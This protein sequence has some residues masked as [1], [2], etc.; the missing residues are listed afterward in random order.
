[1]TITLENSSFQELSD[2]EMNAVDGGAL[3]WIAFGAVL[4]ISFLFGYTNNVN[5]NC[6]C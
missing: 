3:K 6:V 1:M 5:H 4:Y 2:H